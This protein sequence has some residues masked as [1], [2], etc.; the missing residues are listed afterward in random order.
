MVIT[1]LLKIRIIFKN[2][3]FQINKNLLFLISL[4]TRPFICTI[5]LPLVMCNIIKGCFYLFLVENKAFSLCKNWIITLSVGIIKNKIT[6]II[7]KFQSMKV[8]FFVCQNIKLFKVGY[9]KNQTKLNRS[10]IKIFYQFQFSKYKT[11]SIYNFLFKKLL[12]KP[13]GSLKLFTTNI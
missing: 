4:R 3:K 8:Y 2:L 10:N 5:A 11:K 13:K 12:R 9:A 6:F 7:L 1:T